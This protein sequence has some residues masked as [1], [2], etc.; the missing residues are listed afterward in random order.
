MLSNPNFEDANR[1]WQKL[2][3]EIR[4][5]DL[6]YYQHDRPKISDVEYD[7]L[8]REL[9]ELEE[10]FP[11][12]ITSDSPTQKVGAPVIS[13]FAKVEHKIPMLSLANAFSK[14]DLI[15]WE[16]RNRRFLGISEEEK[17]SYV[18]EQKIDG[19]SFSAHYENG[20]FTLGLTRGDGNVGENI[21][22]N[23]A[24][25]LP[26]NLVGDFPEILE[27]RGEVYMSHTHFAALN[28]SL[29]EDK[30]FANP[31]NAAAG[32]LRQ[33]DSKITAS[34]KLDY[35]IYSLGEYSP[36]FIP[37]DSSHTLM[38]V[39]KSYGLNVI[40]QHSASDIAELISYYDEVQKLRVELDYDIDGIVYKID[41][42]NLRKR[43]GEVARAPRWAI[44]H[45]F[46]A[47]KATTIIEAIDIQVGRTGTLTP[48]ARLKPVT[49]GGVVVSNATLHNEDEIRRK[50]IRIGDTVTIQRAG[51]VIPQVVSV[52]ISKRCEG[53]AEYI[54]PTN[55]PVCGSHTVREEGEVA[56]R[57]AGGLLCNAQL[58][59]RLRHFVARGALDI[60][61]LGEKQIQAFWSDGLIVNVADIFSLKE[62]ADE[63]EKREGWGKKS[64]DNLLA[65]IEKAKNVPLEKFVYALGIRHV[66]EVT[67]KLMARY[68]GSAQNWFTAMRQLAE[69]DETVQEDIQNIDGIGGTVVASLEEFFLEKH[70][71]LI[72]EEL[73]AELRVRDA[74]TAGATSAVSGKTVVF[75]GT[76]TKMSRAEAKERAE[77]LG[78]KVAS[79][80]S[81]KTDFV[82]AGADAG[83]KLKKA[84]ELGV[85]VLSEDEWLGMVG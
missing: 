43:L 59:E 37:L 72:V 41:D 81:A 16:A 84:N 30:K 26:T 52:D 58:V 29:P 4:H 45:K 48:V 61:G 35:F 42:L 24:T 57:C 74:K 63:I 80:V 20:K 13:K 7:R 3:E 78:A 6:L 51:D 75:T 50:D 18:C 76:L 22:D 47:E 66:G 10:Q 8:R 56:I 85:K 21:T 44:A 25:I 53:S 33:L 65:A 64:L 67:A 54:F 36:D 49:V 71:R 17:I 62:K 70:N 34:R 2:A 38:S 46:P 15:E 9:E 69:K 23:L 82:V 68:Y 73:L 11:E 83:S 14:E 12:L 27:V 31:R 32:S 19:L 5:H 28:A 40:N 79:S 1:R 77:H 55:C 60:E 39:I